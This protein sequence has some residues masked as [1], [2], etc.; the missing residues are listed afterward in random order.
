M[1]LMGEDVGRYGGAFAVQPRAAR[2]VRPGADPR[3]A[4]LGVDLRRGRHRRGA[5]R[6]AADRR[7]HDRQLQPPGARPDRQQRGH[8]PAHVRRPVQRAARRADGHRR[9]APAGG[10]ALAQPRGLVRAHPRHQGAGAGDGGGRARA[11][12]WRRSR[13]RIPCSSSSTPCSI[14]WRARWTRRP[15]PAISAGARCGAPGDD[16]SLITYGGSLP[17][18]LEAADLLALEGIEAEV[19]DLRTLRPLDADDHPGLRRQDPSGGDRGRGLAHR[20]PR[21][22]DQRPSSWRAAFYEL[23]APVARVCSAEVPM[24]YA[25]HLEDAALPQVPAIAAGG[26]RTAGGSWLSSSCRS[27]A[28][29]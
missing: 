18:T 3:H 20:Q 25:R 17:K 5:G 26:H 28:R 8:P 12:C 27:S 10:A 21:R 16:V 29:T 2:G 4:A 11:C 15:A 9:R 23:D 24:P 22:R 19:I 7:D 6:D 14:R 13:T 1:F